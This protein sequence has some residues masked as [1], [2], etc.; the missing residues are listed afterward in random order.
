MKLNIE[1]RYSLIFLLI[2]LI[3]FVSPCH[4]VFA[5][6]SDPAIELANRIETLAKNAPPE[7]T[8]IQTNKDIYETGEDLWFKVYLLDSKY[9]TPSILS[10]T[11]YLQLLNERTGK[12]VWEEKYEIRNGFSDGRVYINSTLPEGYYLLSV[13]TPY[14]FLGD[15]TEFKALKRVEIRSDITLKANMHNELKGSLTAGGDSSDLQLS[16]FPEGG[17]L[18][19]GIQSKLA[20]KAVNINGYPVD[21]S[22]TLFEDSVAVLRFN[23]IHAGMGSF[24]FIPDNSKKY[25]IRLT[26][27]AT[28]KTFLL[29]EI[30]D[31]GMTMKLGKRD[32]GS[33]NFIVSQSPGLNEQDVYIRIQCRGIVYGMATAHLERELRIKVPVEELP[34]GIAEVTLFNG[35][36]KPVA[37]RLVYTNPERKLNITATISRDV[38]AQR[39]KAELKLNVKDESGRPVIANLGV[40][41][42][43]RSYLNPGDSSNILSHF[44]LAE[45]LKGRIYNPSYYFNNTGKERDE[46]LDLLLLTQGWRR[47]IWS[48]TNLAKYAEESRQVI[49]DYTKGEIFYPYNTRKIPKEET[50]V[51]AF[52]PNRD[53]TK[54]VVQADSSAGFYISPELLKRWENDY[55]I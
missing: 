26:V 14:S 43:D 54:V 7:L 11:L 8:Y 40:S 13:Y 20:F 52:S 55:V 28:N 49:N 50:F 34:Q 27:P 18:V 48:E 44:Y 16:V 12:A 39:G 38:Y 37:E 10:K 46:A 36:L 33:L 24:E 53:S 30:A 17:D 32:N 6:S 23:S 31:E 5:Q 9:L 15:S 45:Q 4:S 3:N 22:G 51:M 29:P 47:Y 42:F 1:N 35:S 41:V 19:S 25:Y 21:V 2:S